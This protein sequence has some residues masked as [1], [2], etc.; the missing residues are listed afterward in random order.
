[1]TQSPHLPNKGEKCDNDGHPFD[2][3]CLRTCSVD[4]RAAFDKSIKT[5]EGLANDILE[6]NN[7][8]TNSAWCKCGAGSVNHNLKPTPTKPSESWE[9]AKG[10]T[11]DCCPCMFEERCNV[12]SK[13][14]HNLIKNA[15]QCTNC[16]RIFEDTRDWERHL[17]FLSYAKS[18]RKKAVDT[19][20]NLAIDKMLKERMTDLYISEEIKAGTLEV[21]DFSMPSD[22]KMQT[23]KEKLEGMLWWNINLETAPE[24]EK[25]KI[26]NELLSFIHQV[27]KEER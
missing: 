9:K 27:R 17:D 21:K 2:S 16:K 3:S 7:C 4:R 10:F 25:E 12:H 26:F 1:M 8:T 20:M 19:V 6:S 14:Q 5:L 11:H 23:I 18:E 13:P 22:Y 15:I 24:E